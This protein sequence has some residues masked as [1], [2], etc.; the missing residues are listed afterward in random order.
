MGQTD[1]PLR[2]NTNK[3]V[4]NLGLGDAMNL[5]WKLASTIRGN[6]PAGLLDS[7]FSERHPVGA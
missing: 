5:G 7:Y 4:V 3:G 2:S 6:A 1:E